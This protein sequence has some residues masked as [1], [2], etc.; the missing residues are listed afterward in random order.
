MEYL[1]LL[2]QIWAIITSIFCVIIW[3]YFIVVIGYHTIN[4]LFSKKETP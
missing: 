3:F 4:I 2:I 1:I